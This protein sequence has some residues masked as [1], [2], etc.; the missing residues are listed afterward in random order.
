MR[1]CVA[2]AM[3]EAATVFRVPIS[4]SNHVAALLGVRLTSGEGAQVLVTPWT[5][6]VVGIGSLDGS[7][8]TA[9]ECAGKGLLGVWGAA[10]TGFGVAHE[11][12]LGWEVL[13][14]LS[15]RCLTGALQIR[16]SVPVET[17]RVIP[18]SAGLAVSI[19]DVVETHVY[20]HAW[21]TKVF[22]P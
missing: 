21:V 22:S 19:S 1:L 13:T 5:A 15:Y 9:L 18:G 11:G 2:E 6:V 7:G 14:P 16:S 12:S 17:L 20:L 4:Q 10:W 3:H 8:I